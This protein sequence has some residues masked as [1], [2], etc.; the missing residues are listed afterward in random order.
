MR[1]KIDEGQSNRKKKRRHLTRGTRRYDA[2]VAQTQFQR[3]R[4]SRGEP[5]PSRA[6]RNQPEPPREESRPSAFDR[7][8]DGIPWRSL[9]RSLPVVLLL[10]ILVATLTFISVDDKFFVFSGQVVG[11]QRMN[12]TDIYV[13]SGVDAQHI[14]WIQ[15]DEVA[16][17]INQM[18]GI[19]SARVRCQLPALVTIEVQERQPVVMWRLKGQGRDLWL[20]AEGVVLPYHGEADA[21][22]TL[23]VVDSSDRHLS[24]G[25]YLE[26]AGT[27]ESVVQLAAALPGARVFF[28]REDKGLG[29][30]QRSSGTEW[31]VYVGTSKDIESKIR[32]VEQIS[33]HLAE[34]NIHPTYVDVR[35]PERAVYGLPAGENP[36]GG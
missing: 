25:D 10:G 15:P 6:Q 20:D 33:A 26:P 29:F 31:P 11:A 23:F 5:K 4:D 24:V 1:I 32:V 22:E 19:K 17:A 16:V 35:W 18:E 21:P 13:A 34:E 27:V 12:A 36:D 2:A 28:Y 7:L 14:L 8:L 30:T 9:T 3:V